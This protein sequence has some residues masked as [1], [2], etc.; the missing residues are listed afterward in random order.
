[1]NITR[2]TGGSLSYYIDEYDT[3]GNWISGQYKQGVSFPW[4]QTAGFTYSPSSNNVASASLQVVAPA[5]SGIQA[6]LDNFQWI[7]LSTPTTPPP[8][9]TN[10]MPNGTFDAGISQGWTTD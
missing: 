7:A 2:L 5:N 6:Y 4:P 8:V 1:M 9:Q 10:L 3:N